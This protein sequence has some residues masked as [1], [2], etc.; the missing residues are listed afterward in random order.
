[1]TTNEILFDC[2]VEILRDTPTH[3]LWLKIVAYIQDY[4]LHDGKEVNNNFSHDNWKG[5]CCW[6]ER[7]D[8]D[9]ICMVPLFGRHSLRPDNF[10]LFLYIK[11]RK[12]GSLFIWIYLLFQVFD[13]IR[14][15]KDA[16]GIPHTSGLL[17]NYFVLQ[18]FGFKLTFKLVN[19][20]VESSFPYG[21]TGVFTRY[22]TQDDNKRVLE[23]Y[24]E[25]K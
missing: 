5:V 13:A 20:R 21:W 19:W 22:Y 11:H 7:Y 15:R 10:F 14:M 16:Q 4:R 17:L 25:R 18:T 2:E 8:K 1:M 23:A 3:D 9:L 12:I 24:L 6:L